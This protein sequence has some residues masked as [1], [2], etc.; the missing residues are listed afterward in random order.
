MLRY[1]ILGLLVR[2]F[3]VTS[4]KAP[5]GSMQHNFL[6][7]ISVFKNKIIVKCHSNTLPSRGCKF[8]PSMKASSEAECWHIISRLH[9]LVTAVLHANGMPMGE[10]KI[11]LN[12]NKLQA[13]ASLPVICTMPQAAMRLDAIR[14]EIKFYTV[15]KGKKCKKTDERETNIAEWDCLVFDEVGCCFL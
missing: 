7:D 3:S 15:N 14:G 1:G 4:M 13:V 8:S 6:A 5:R 11:I 10:Q 2:N 12:F 9:L